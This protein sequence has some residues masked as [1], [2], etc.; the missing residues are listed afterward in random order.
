MAQVIIQSKR[1]RTRFDEMDRIMDSMFDNLPSFS[2]IG[3]LATR[4]PAVDVVE[5][6]DR[7]LITAELPGMDETQ[8]DIR[9]ETGVLTI[10]SIDQKRVQGDSNN[11]GEQTTNKEAHSGAKT[12]TRYLIRERRY[13]HFSRNFVL[14]KDVTFDSITASFSNGLLT[15]ELPKEE[16]SLPRKIEIKTN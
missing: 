3:S 9:V 15:L 5:E 10:S 13:T 7:Y 2:R 14:P 4:T 1:P 11:S 16:K 8:I 6:E 12:P